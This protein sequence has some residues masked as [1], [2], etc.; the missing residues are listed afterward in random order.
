MELPKLPEAFFSSPADLLASLQGVFDVSLSVLVIG[1]VFAAVFL[2]ALFGSKKAMVSSLFALVFTGFLFLMFPYWG[3]LESQQGA[4]G[5]NADIYVKIGALAIFFIAARFAVGSSVR[6]NYRYEK[7]H[8]VMEIIGLSIAVSG[9]LLIYGYQFTA[10]AGL[11]PLSPAVSGFLTAPQTFFWW[12]VGSL[13]IVY[14][15]SD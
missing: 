14:L 8:K 7:S 11:Y 10:L 6:G 9:L 13:F 15:S 4:L 5:T 1:G 2:Y 3:L 12:L